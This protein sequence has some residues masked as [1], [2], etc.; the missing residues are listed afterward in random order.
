MAAARV[1][2]AWGGR[3]PVSLLAGTTRPCRY[4]VTVHGNRHPRAQAGPILVLD[5]VARHAVAAVRGLGRAGWDVVVAGYKRPADALAAKSR[6]ASGAYERLPDPHG[7]AAPYEE[8]LAEVVRRRGCQAVVAVSDS[9]IA[10]L[11]QIDVPVP[12]VPPMNAGLDRVIDKLGLGAIA[13]GA[14]VD[15]PSTWSPGL[16]APASAGWPRIVKPRRTSMAGP[17]RVVGRTG[18]F[19]VPDQ[20]A[21]DAAVAALRE[22]E[23]EPIIQVR[24][25]RAFKVTVAIVR[26]RG[27]TTF[28]FA[29]EVLLEYPPLG[30]QAAAIV[31]IAPH[32]GIG[33]RAIHT[34]E[35]VCDAAGYEGLANVQMY[36]QEDGSI[37][38]IEVN[39]RVW[40]SVW[41]PEHLGLRPVE[42]AV[43]AALDE[44][45]LPPLDYPVGRRF[46]RPTLEARW[47]LA[48][49]RDREAAW[50]LPAIIRPWD[51][52]DLLSV[53]DPRPFAAGLRRM[54]LRSREELGHKTGR[55]GG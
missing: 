6:Y 9:T 4:D 29:Y 18:A 2:L 50:R 33:A 16:P 23:L 54:L 25:S 14:D 41:L 34:A 44:E 38:L 30:G 13:A 15:Y 53:T 45:P 35:R 39:P 20:A 36:G 37:C 12:T 11:R 52:F 17:G 46:H 47:L 1:K 7:E 3:R 24:V 55:P 31:S 49:R 42:R 32:R 51:V 48:P 5:P 28:R 19:V 43:L 26:H 10:R 22:L 21:E 40:G 8:A 27:R